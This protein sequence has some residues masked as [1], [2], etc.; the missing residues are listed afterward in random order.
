MNAWMQNH[1]PMRN[2]VS[3]ICRIGSPTALSSSASHSPETLKAKSSSLDLTSTGKPVARY[4]NESTAS[5]SQVRQ[6]DVNSSVS[7]GKIAAETDKE[8]RW[9]MDA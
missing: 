8:L 9:Y 3:K 7:A 5:R 6:S 2:L 1:K 4:S